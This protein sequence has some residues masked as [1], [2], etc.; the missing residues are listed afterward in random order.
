MSTIK[1]AIALSDLHLGKDKG[2]LY[3]KDSKYKNNRDAVLDLLQSLGPQDE[4]IL[5]GDFLELSLR[6][7]LRH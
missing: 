3:S 1:S 6:Q 2:Y 4:L 5:A 7:P